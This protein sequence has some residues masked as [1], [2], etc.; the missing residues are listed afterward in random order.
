MAS[1]CSGCLAGGPRAALAYVRSNAIVLLGLRLLLAETRR[2]E[3]LSESLG[4]VAPARVGR[5]AE[6][7]SRGIPG[8]LSCGPAQE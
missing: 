2:V 6:A 5:F 8:R 7:H 1:F 3:V 4:F